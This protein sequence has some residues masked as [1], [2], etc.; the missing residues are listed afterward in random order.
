MLKQLLYVHGADI[1]GE[2]GGTVGFGVRLSR[3]LAPGF[4]VTSLTMPEPLRPTYAKW[5]SALIKVMPQLHDKLI[6]VGHSLGGSVAL[7]LFAQERPCTS[8]A[9]LFVIAAPYWGR[10]QG[11]HDKDFAFHDDLPGDLSSIPRIF[12]YHS[13]DDVI[14]PFSHLALYAAKLPH[15][16]VRALDGYGH[17]FAKPEFH[18][19]LEDIQRTAAE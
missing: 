1:P 12:L 13:R 5:R 6:V 2:A 7:K 4:N 9:A 15:A 11:W 19:L 10:E 14:V 18:E 16:E 8:V 3:S 17:W